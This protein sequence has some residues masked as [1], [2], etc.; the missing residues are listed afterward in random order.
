[1]KNILKIND[2]KKEEIIQI[3]D[4]SE[5]YENYSNNILNGK[6]IL[7]A[8]EK[9]SLRTTIGTE[10]AINQLGGNVIHINPQTFFEGDII[11]SNSQKHNLTGREALKDIVNN[12]CKFCDVI[13]A[14]VK[15]HQTLVEVAYHSSI[16]VINALCDIHHPMQAL[17]D[18][19]TIQKNFGN[20][21]IKLAFIGDA[22]NVAFSLFEILLIF[23]HSI[24][25]AG[26]KK[27]FFP[28][29]LQYYFINLANKHGG[30]IEFLVD[31]KEA[32]KNA[33]IIYT[34]TFVQM[35]QEHIYED[36]IK[37]F[38][39]Y[40][41][42]IKLLSYTEKESYFMHC[43]PAHRGVE[44]TDEVIDSKKSLVYKQAENRMVVSKGVFTY[45]FT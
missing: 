8:F 40:Q 31:P 34:D 6:N 29:N 12:V 37:D 23:G 45:L 16:P 35:G 22:N 5:K 24:S 2:L 3:L 27:Y 1:M 9:P 25:F 13:F 44:V 20:K 14:R 4:L 28:G 10:S 26:P 11:H 39:K 21:K 7:F 32:I 42:N 19:Y 30:E 41:V 36:K 17:A 43:L 18:L 15:Y 33:D 38:L